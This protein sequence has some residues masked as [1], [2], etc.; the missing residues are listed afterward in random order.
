M[1][2]GIYSFWIYF[3]S[4]TL[5]KSQVI[6]KEFCPVLKMPSKE[7]LNILTYGHHF[8]I[9]FLSLPLDFSLTSP[10]FEMSGIN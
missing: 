10:E 2:K 8:H 4:W 5:Q 6:P 1:R 9:P 3:L 7:C